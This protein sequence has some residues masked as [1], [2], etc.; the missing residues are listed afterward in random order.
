MQTVYGWPPKGVKSRNECLR[1][2]VG[3]ANIRVEMREHWLRWI[4]HVITGEMIRA[5]SRLFKRLRIEGRGA[6][7]DPKCLG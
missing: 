4:G 3:V 7:P 5:W 2:S 6:E 1:E